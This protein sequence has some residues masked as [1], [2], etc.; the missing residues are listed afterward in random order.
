MAMHG[1][2]YSCCS[3][4]SDPIIN[5]WREGGWEFVK[6]ALNVPDFVAELSGLADVQRRTDELEW[7]V[8]EDEE[9]EAATMTLDKE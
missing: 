4:C 2:S 6:K 7:D 3:A 9:E 1:Q 5:G 8:D